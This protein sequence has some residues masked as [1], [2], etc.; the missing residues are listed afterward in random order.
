MVE[1]EAG[2]VETVPRAQPHS[3]LSAVAIVRIGLGVR[4]ERVNGHPVNVR[5]VRAEV[6]EPDTLRALL[7]DG[8]PEVFVRNPGQVSGRLEDDVFSSSHHAVDVLVRVLVHCK[9]SALED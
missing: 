2:Q 5:D 7:V 1:P 6:G 8:T 3:V 4:T 9:L